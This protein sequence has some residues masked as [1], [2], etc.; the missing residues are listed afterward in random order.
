MKAFFALSIYA[1]LILTSCGGND[2]SAFA[3]KQKLTSANRAEII[4]SNGKSINVGVENDALRLIKSSITDQD[5]KGKNCL[6]DGKINFYTQNVMVETVDFAIQ[7]GCSYVNYKYNNQSYKK[8]IS[9]EAK[10]YL[11]EA[12]RN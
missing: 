7:P 8:S 9:A 10:K 5:F 11:E 12:G 6:A 1:I 2:E 3:V 4:F